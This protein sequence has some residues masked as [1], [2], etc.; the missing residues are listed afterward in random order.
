MLNGDKTNLGVNPSDTTVVL[1]HQ[2]D[3]G[4]R[5]ETWFSFRSR[6]FD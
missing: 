6:W 3:H 5:K 2:L 1:G 4:L